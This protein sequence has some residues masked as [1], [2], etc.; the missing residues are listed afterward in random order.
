MAYEIFAQDTLTTTATSIDLTSIPATHTHLELV[1][2]ARS[3]KVSGA[4]D[5][6]ELTFNG[7][8]GSNYGTIGAYMMNST[9]VS[10]YN[11]V[12]N[13]RNQLDNPFR[14]MN[15]AMTA[16]LYC[17]SKIVIPNY[18]STTITRKGAIIQCGTGGDSTSV[19]WLMISHAS[20][21]SAAAIN[22]ITLFAESAS[23]PFKAGTSYYLAGWE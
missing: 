22:Q 23:Y 10:P 15:D 7:D 11:L 18:A 4:T 2:N 13:S 19:Y 5:G 21:S 20:W 9:S 6:G 1:I 3:T 17:P 12:P 14:I 8:T 16:N